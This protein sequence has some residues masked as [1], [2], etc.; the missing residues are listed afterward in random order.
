MSKSNK[1]VVNETK[2]VIVHYD[3]MD[4]DLIH[5]SRM[6]SSIKGGS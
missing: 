4:S 6:E 1:S 5:H 2:L 3:S